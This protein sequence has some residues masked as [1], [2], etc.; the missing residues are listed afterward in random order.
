MMYVEDFTRHWAQS[1]CLVTET[2][3]WICCSKWET[4]QGRDNHLDALECGSLPIRSR[5]IL[6][7]LQGNR[8]VLP[9]GQEHADGC[10]GH[11]NHEGLGSLNP[12]TPILAPPYPK[13]W[14]ERSSQVISQSQTCGQSTLI[15]PCP[16]ISN[17][18]MFWVA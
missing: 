14:P 3:C 8:S 11:L 18:K 6:I 16:F 9:V 4:R 15:E 2:C 17:V 13:P 10:E 7:F 1:S 5:L 12:M